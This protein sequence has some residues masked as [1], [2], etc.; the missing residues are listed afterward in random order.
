MRLALHPKHA[1]RRCWQCLIA[2]LPRPGD[3]EKEKKTRT[4]SRAKFSIHLS[5]A[6]AGRVS[7]P[8]SSMV[9]V[10]MMALLSPS[11]KQVFEVAGQQHFNLPFTDGCAADGRALPS[12]R[13]TLDLPYEFSARGNHRLAPSVGWYSHFGLKSNG[14]C[15]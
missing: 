6:L 13:A 8:Y 15:K 9:S 7:R 3:C 11:V 14:T 5:L 12:S 4:S 1:P 2:D 10:G